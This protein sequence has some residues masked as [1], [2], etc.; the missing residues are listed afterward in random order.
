[1]GV[2]SLTASEL[3]DLAGK[4]AADIQST[5]GIF[6]SKSF[7]PTRRVER[8]LQG[9]LHRQELQAEIQNI[10]MNGGDPSIT[11]Y[12]V[13]SIPRAKLK[14]ILEMAKLGKSK[15]P[16]DVPISKGSIEFHESVSNLFDL[17]GMDEELYSET[18]LANRNRL[19]NILDRL[20]SM[21]LSVLSFGQ[22]RPKGASGH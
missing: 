8:Q 1:M 22:R 4:L 19:R 13:N 18:F 17:Q 5:L 9:W 3:V 20:K 14:R 21:D 2:E 7:G 16:S 12:Y 10:V 15:T 11:Y 6:G